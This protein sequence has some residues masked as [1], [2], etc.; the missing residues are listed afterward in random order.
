MK[1]STFLL[2][3]E[4]QRTY[5]KSM[6]KSA[7]LWSRISTRSISSFKRVNERSLG[8]TKFRRKEKKELRSSRLSSR[9]LKR[10]GKIWTLNTVLSIFK[11][12]KLR[13][14]TKLQSVILTMQ[15]TSFISQI[16]SGMRQSWDWVKRS[17]GLDPYRMWSGIKK[18]R[19]I[20]EPWRLRTWTEE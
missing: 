2:N 11:T 13:I 17:K 9:I 19:C 4:R 5:K 18:S 10:N 20:K 12:I 7:A 3:W 14:S 16:K 1:N 6:R 15:L 8:S